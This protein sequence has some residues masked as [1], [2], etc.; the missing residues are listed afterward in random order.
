MPLDDR[1]YM[2]SISI[3]ELISWNY[4]Y[5]YKERKMA[6][7]A[8]L[9]AMG[10]YAAAKGSSDS[11]VKYTKS[12]AQIQASLRNVIKNYHDDV[13]G[14]KADVYKICKTREIDAKEVFEAGTDPA[15]VENYSNKATS[16]IKARGALQELEKDL[17]ELQ[18]LIGA[19]QHGQNRIE[20]FE[21]VI[22]NIESARTFDLTYYELVSFGF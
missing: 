8:K 6:S 22:R 7:K 10:M 12:G 14:F 17:N 1:E 21:R 2:E 19:I 13:E 4:N 16:N 9:W 3:Q 11:D 5:I 18:N 20:Y 15:E